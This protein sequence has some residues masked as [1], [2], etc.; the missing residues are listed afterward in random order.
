MKKLLFILTVC[1]V[2][3]YSQKSEQVVLQNADVFAGKRLPNGEDVRELTGNVRFKQGDTRVWCD[4]AIQFLNRNEIELIGNVKIVRDTVTLTAKKGRYFGNSRKSDGEGDVKLQTPNVTL[5]A[6]LGTYYLDEGKAFF[7]RNVRVVDSATIIYS[8]QLTYFENQRRSEAMLN[9]RIVNMDDNITMFG[10]HLIHSD[11]T[12]YSRMTE[13]PRL[14]QIDTSEAGEIDTL[15]VKSMVMESYDDST[16]TMI[17]KDSVVIVRGSLAARSG[18]VK[19]FRQKER[20]ELFVKPIVWYQEN[21]VIGDTIFLTLEKN[22]LKTASIRTR[23]FVISQSDSLYPNR[24]NQLTGRAIL[25]TF[26]DN[27][28]QETVVERN[29][30]SLYFLY[31]DSAGN[32]VNKTSGDAITMKFNDGK[33]NTIHILKGIEGTYFPETLLEQNESQYN[34]DGFF[35]RR[36]RP[37]FSTVFPT[38]P[39]L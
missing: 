31:G 32:G 35:L 38:K 18:L 8:E 27:K 39:K 11:S 9:V 22:R 33:P 5:Y 6:D 16:K 13:N 17:V 14:I 1:S 29:A 10:N 24:Y 7:Q 20:I 25:M 15:A 36:D 19:F 30:I 21:Q 2:L 26:D 3:L 34:L 28:L 37:E 23:A 12:R 4:K